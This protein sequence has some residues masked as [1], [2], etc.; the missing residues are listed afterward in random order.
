MI[1]S[2]GYGKSPT[3]ALTFNFGPLNQEGGW[4]RLNV[5]VTRARWHTI[6]VTSMRSQE[7]AGVNPNNRGAVA[8]RNFIAYAER[9]G[10]LPAEPVRVTSG[11][12]NDFEDA[13]AEV[14]RERGYVV[15][16]QVGASEYRIDLAIRDPRD[17]QRYLLGV[18]CDGA[19]YHS[20]KTARDRDLLR[21]Q[22]LREQGWRLYRLWSTN[23]FRDREAALAGALR[24]I[25]QAQQEPLEE[26]VPATAAPPPPPSSAGEGAPDKQFD[27][28]RSR[29]EDRA[30]PP[31]AASAQ[32]PVGEPY[33]KYRGPGERRLLLHRDRAA[34]LATQ[35]ARIVAHEGPIH[36]DLL[37]ER[38]KEI[39]DVGRAGA[40]IQA[41]IEWAIKLA[42]H[43]GK[44]E[45]SGETF[46]KAKGASRTTFRGP[47]DGVERALAWV[48]PEEIVLAVLHIVEDQFGCQRDALPRAIGELFGF[49]R[50]PTGLADKVQL[51][52]DGLIEEG[53]L[54]VSG[55]WIYL[56]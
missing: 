15:D 24:A 39:N 14:L 37:I 49:G 3:G 10:A 47:G 8:L 56:A 22:V 6:L 51:V 21:Q 52:V 42:A 4:R 34:Q 48:P 25:E 7:L 23:W 11:E 17:P 38:L 28:A 36:V 50:A 1:I 13:V 2:V 41:N 5:L 55:P 45:R 9:G 40:N 35:V 29:E 33:A 43:S 53:R 18:E 31:A 12:T 16:Q 54:V 44:V 30:T 46:L 26:S 32:Y 27:S 19:T 20:A